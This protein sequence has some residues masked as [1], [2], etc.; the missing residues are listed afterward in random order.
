MDSSSPPG[1]G[2]AWISFP[3]PGI[4]YVHTSWAYNYI[5]SDPKSDY[6]SVGLSKPRM[7]AILLLYRKLQETDLDLGLQT[8]L[9]A[10]VT[11]GQSK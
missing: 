11:L 3:S 4:T 2:V 10:P 1:V 9:H 5:G 7:R 6:G 8:G